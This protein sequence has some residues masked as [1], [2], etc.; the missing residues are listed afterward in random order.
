MVIRV[1][2]CPCACVL[3]DP[4]F[5]FS[6]SRNRRCCPS[7]LKPVVVICLATFPCGAPSVRSVTQGGCAMS[8]HLATIYA[9]AHFHDHFINNK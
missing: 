5:I 4:A 7:S 2:L 3:L 1:R 6:C 9:Q 8:A